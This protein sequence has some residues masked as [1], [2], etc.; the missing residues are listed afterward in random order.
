MPFFLSVAS[1]PT[2]V[3]TDAEF[4]A[5]DIIQKYTDYSLLPNSI[6]MVLDNP[7]VTTPH[8]NAINI[9]IGNNTVAL[10]TASNTAKRLNLFPYILTKTM[11]GD[12]GEVGEQLGN[13]LHV[14][15]YIFR[16]TKTDQFLSSYS[17]AALKAGEKLK[18]NKY[19]MDELLKHVTDPK[20]QSEYDGVC[21]LIGGETTVNVRSD[22]G[23]GGRNQELTLSAGMKIDTCANN[24]YVNGKVALLSAGTDGFDGPCNAAGA[25][26][27]CKMLQRGYEKKLSPTQYL[28]DNNS[29]EYFRANSGGAYHI[30]TGHTETNVMDLMILLV[31]K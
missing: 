31:V 23:V 30:I 21:V 19:K 20:I 18:V 13:F 10:E 26:L 16:A 5:R 8:K 6:Q 17:T 22:W 9:I 24:L 15:S 11:S 29:Y 2:V 14:L 28:D 3:N 27:D 4:L 12:A 25:V 1:G 7:V